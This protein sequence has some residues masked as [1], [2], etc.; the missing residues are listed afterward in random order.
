VNHEAYVADFD[1]FI[2]ILSTRMSVYFAFGVVWTACLIAFM[3]SEKKRY[4]EH[5]RH[6]DIL[7]TFSFDKLKP[8]AAFH[9]FYEKYYAQY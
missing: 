3:V 7:L 5:E 4:E 9:R 6:H 1:N 8:L 2:S